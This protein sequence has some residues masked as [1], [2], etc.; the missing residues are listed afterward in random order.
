MRYIP[1]QDLHIHS[2]LSPCSGDPEQTTERILRY[3][4]ENGLRHICLTDHVWDSAVPGGTFCSSPGPGTFRWHDFAYNRKAL[5]LPQAEGVTFHFGA[6]AD[7]DR[8][9]TIG[10]SRKEADALDFFVVP[11]THMHILGFPEYPALS[12]EVKARRETY[13]ARWEKLLDADLPFYKIG[14]AHLTCEG[15][16][17]CPGAEWENHLAV[18][19]S[20]PDDVFTDHFARTQSL[21]MGVELNTALESYENNGLDRILRVYK[22]A[23]NAGCRFYMGSDAHHPATLEKALPR[24]HRWVELLNL[25][26]EQKFCPFE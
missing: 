21:G 14:I 2:Q 25:E 9:A 4:V 19:D 18:L 24:F 22:L 26:E 17:K 5:P 1:D 8:T 7:M 3:A 23:V 13:L 20:I 11:T 16:C 10:M 6:E 12:D 15:I